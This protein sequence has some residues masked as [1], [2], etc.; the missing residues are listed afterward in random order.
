MKKMLSSYNLLIHDG[1]QQDEMRKERMKLVLSLLAFECMSGKDPGTHICCA[2][3]NFVDAHRAQN[4][5][6]A[7]VAWNAWNA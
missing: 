1:F 7:A 5:A 3:K 2:K 6:V 4:R